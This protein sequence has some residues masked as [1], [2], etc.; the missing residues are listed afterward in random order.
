MSTI[1]HNNY[2]CSNDLTFQVLPEMQTMAVTPLQK[3]LLHYQEMA[4]NNK[5]NLKENADGDTAN[6]AANHIQEKW[7]SYYKYYCYAADAIQGG[8]SGQVDRMGWM[9]IC[10]VHI[11]PGSALAVVKLAEMAEQVGNI[12]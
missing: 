2:L 1:Q 12:E 3:S 11:L 4:D 7:Q 9:W 10:L 8:P 6:G 5:A